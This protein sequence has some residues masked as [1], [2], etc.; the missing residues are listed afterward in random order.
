MADADKVGACASAPDP[1]KNGIPCRDVTDPNA[2]YTYACVD[3]ACTAIP[4][5]TKLGQPCINDAVN[6]TVC[7][8]LVCAVRPSVQCLRNNLIP[9]SPLLADPSPQAVSSSPTPLKR[10]TTAAPARVSSVWRC[11]HRAYLVYA[12]VIGGLCGRLPGCAKRQLHHPSGRLLCPRRV[13]PP[14]RH[15]H[16]TRLTRPLIRRHSPST[17]DG[18]HPRPVRSPD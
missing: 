8:K 17:P 1:A 12:N 3:G 16:R 2:C 15:V 6:V 11:A 7:N 18:P 14:L 10:A 4:D 13:R 5:Q 9:Y